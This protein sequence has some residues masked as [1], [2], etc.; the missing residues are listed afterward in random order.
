MFCLKFCKIYVVR[1]LEISVLESFYCIVIESIYDIS[2]QKLI[3]CYLNIKVTN[4]LVIV[5][6]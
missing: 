2:I 6:F 1:V 3:I 5:E 4:K